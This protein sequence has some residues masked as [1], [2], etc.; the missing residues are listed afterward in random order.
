[1]NK[2]SDFGKWLIK[3]YISGNLHPQLEI[4]NVQKQ[5]KM[6]NIM[7]YNLKLRNLKELDDKDRLFK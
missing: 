5:E 3:F 7:I 2:K 1:M 4:V 6:M